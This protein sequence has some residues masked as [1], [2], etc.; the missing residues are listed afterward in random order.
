M[1]SQL[2]SSPVDIQLRELL[3]RNGR[4]CIYDPDGKPFVVLSGVTERLSAEAMAEGHV[5][6]EGETTIDTLRV[7][8]PAGTLGRGISLQLRKRLAFDARADLLTIS[9]ATLQMGD[10]PV[11]LTGQVAEVST[12][13]PV[14]DLRLEGGPASI[15]NL[16]GYLPDAMFPEM[17]GMRSEGTLSLVAIIR[18]ALAPQSGTGAELAETSGGLIPEFTLDLTLSEGRIQHP[19]LPAP[20]EEVTLQLHADPDTIEI[21]EFAA[22]SGESRLRVRATVT[23]YRTRPRLVVELDADVDLSDIAALQPPQDSLQ[24]GGRAVAQLV[25]SGAVDDPT[26]VSPAGSSTALTPV[27]TIRLIGAAA[28]TPQLPVALQNLSGLITLRERELLIQNLQGN[29]GASDL[30]LNGTVANYTALS[31]QAA[32]AGVATIDLDLHSKRLDLDEL[33]PPPGQAGASPRMA[34]VGSQAGSTRDAGE[35]VPP[36]ALLACLEG[37]IALHVDELKIN[38][39]VARR[40]RGTVQ[41]DRGVINL[42]GVGLEAFGGQLAAKGAVDYR[43]PESPHF[44]VQMQLQQIQAGQLYSYANDLNRFGRLGGFLSG[45]IDV[46]VKMSG[47]L[48]DSLGLNLETF[49]S[50]G[51]M[52]TRSASIT[53]HPLQEALVAFLKAPQLGKLAVSDW[54]QPFDIQNGRVVVDGMRLKADQVELSATGWQSIDGALAL[55][56][57]LLLPRE[58]S[59]DLR[60]KLPSE[61]VPILF[62][63]SGNRILVPLE[64]SGRL[65]RPKVSLSMDKLREGARQ[66]AEQ[67][68]AAERERLQQEVLDQAGELLEDLLGADQDSAA[69]AD[70]EQ[71]SKQ[72]EKKVKDLL[73]NLFRKKK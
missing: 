24:L 44:D 59:G 50:T 69:Q 60:A 36:A 21:T 47:D 62:D 49:S 57:E 28:T 48:N 41:L 9:Q 15:G 68:L 67:R 72:V 40:A 1:S 14:A 4:V 19:M 8:L 13:T 27:G 51:N 33:M 3:V 34:D 10:L 2:A 37:R 29:L 54:Q 39:A 30:R 7:H 73:K 65:P 53:G 26:G 11:A 52:Q 66:R 5:R 17:E 63:G 25:V 35:A 22:R 56:V 42:D 46:T 64:I 58:L 71:K 20:V 55:S 45:E 61:L 43:R 12:G 6:L 38:R 16:L 31:P 23:N 18:G 70:Q 32:N